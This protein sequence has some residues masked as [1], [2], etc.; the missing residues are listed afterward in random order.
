MSTTRVPVQEITDLAMAACVAAGATEEMARSIICALISADRAGRHQMGIA[1]LPTYLDSLKVGR[2]NGKATPR[3]DGSF[4]AF[5]HADADGGV[6]Q[7]CFD[8]VFNT[9]V[10]SA[11]T[12]G[13]AALAQRNSYTTGELGYYVR[14]LAEVD[15]VALAFTNGPALMAARI[16]GERVFCTNPLAFGVP[17]PAPM[18]PMV[19]DQAS[20]ATAFVNIKKAALAG[21]AI[22]GGWAI[23]AAG[24]PTTDPAQAILGALLPFGGYKGA[25]LALL[26]E[27]MSAGLSGAAWS[28]DAGDLYD[29]DRPLDTGLSI[30]ALEPEAATSGF[31]ERVADQLERLRAKGVTI[32]GKRDPHGGITSQEFFE[33]EVNL[34][35]RL[36]ALAGES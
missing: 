12:C 32:P 21:E 24:V 36:V 31:G 29:G 33:I 4:P 35:E 10:R 15:L 17:L 13:I 20:S 7:H 22:P 6:A 34:K 19:I 5:L 2:I 14:R 8:L 30:I 11:R 26:V 27:I 1:H 16:G 28:L 23:D 25:N 9:L 3:F 18:S